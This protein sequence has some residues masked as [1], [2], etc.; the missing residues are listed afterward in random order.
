M[1]QYRIC[2]LFSGSGGN[3]ALIEAAGTRILIDAGKSARTLCRAL[4][5]VDCD[6]ATLDA[7]FITHEHSDH[8]SALEVLCKKY[9]TPIHITEE[10]AARFDRLPPSPLHDCLVRHTPRFSVAVGELRVQSFC[11]PHDSRM[12]VGYRI[13]FELDGIP[14]A[15]GLATDIGYVTEEIATALEGCEA[16]ILES[17]HDVEMLKSGSYPYDLKKRILSR[18]GHLSNADS[19]VFSSHLAAHG[20]KAFLLA[21]LSEENNTPQLAYDAHVATL[22]DPRLTVAVASAHEPTQL[23]FEEKE[24]ILQC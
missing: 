9:R 5:S 2:T 24:V 22:A 19:A 20:T 14:H 23:L 18:R 3:A 21:H 13:E 10:S 12:S 15:V 17:N 4:S 7:I 6:P 1:I 8:V 11:T 16:V